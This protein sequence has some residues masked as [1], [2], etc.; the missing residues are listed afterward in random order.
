MNRF[1]NLTEIMPK[2]WTIILLA[3]SMVVQTLSIASEVLPSHL[4]DIHHDPGQL[5]HSI[6]KHFAVTDDVPDR[7]GNSEFPSIPD[8]CHGSHCHGCH[9]VLIMHGLVF[10]ALISEQIVPSNTSQNK[11]VPHARILRPPIA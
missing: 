5:H 1:F 10:P 8:H 4:G 11:S 7:R 9:L 6:G 3:I 2:V